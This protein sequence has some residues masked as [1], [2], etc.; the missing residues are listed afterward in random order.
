MVATAQV[1]VDAVVGRPATVKAI[2]VSPTLVNHDNTGIASWLWTIV[3]KPPTSTAVL[4][5]SVNPAPTIGPLDAAGTYLVRLQVNGAT[6]DWHT[7]A[8]VDEISIRVPNALGVVIPAPWETDQGGTDGWADWVSGMNRALELLSGA[9]FTLQA[10]YTA[11]VPPRVL[12]DPAQGPV[13]F[14]GQVGVTALGQWEDTGAL[15]RMLLSNTGLLTLA[16]KP[17]TA[18]AG[19][20]ILGDNNSLLL[21]MLDT[22]LLGSM[23]W[24]GTGQTI[25][26][27]GAILGMGVD[28]HAIEADAAH[29]MSHILCYRGHANTA[30]KV[31]FLT[32]GGAVGQYPGVNGVV[33]NTASWV[34]NLLDLSSIGNVLNAK[35]STGFEV[36]GRGV[37]VDAGGTLIGFLADLEGTINGTA[38]AFSALCKT[39][40]QPAYR[41]GYGVGATPFVGYYHFNAAD[42]IAPAG[43]AAPTGV[44]IK[45]LIPTFGVVAAGAN[46]ELDIAVGWFASGIVYSVYLTAVGGST[47]ATL[48]FSYQAGVYDAANLQYEA[49]NTDVSLHFSDVV[50]WACFSTDGHLHAK[51]TNNG[52]VPSTFN[53]SIVGMGQ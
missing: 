7:D 6:G 39:Q 5:S 34:W 1:Y 10:C 43:A 18:Q 41:V 38:V 23:G 29:V 9:H 8:A 51:V 19:L 37:T 20:S 52:S 53:L 26:T 17:G 35:T 47:R 24:F 25:E 46:A 2:G 44:Q 28:L 32:G 27:A 22:T 21:T 31:W 48:Q 3:S 50:P 15:I 49:D 12:L 36:Y 14:R 33:D 45:S 4:S 40:A 13:V 42:A 16:P 30:Q 11:S